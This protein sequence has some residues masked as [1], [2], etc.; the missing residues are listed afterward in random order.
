MPMGKHDGN[1]RLCIVAVLALSQCGCC[2]AEGDAEPARRLSLRQPKSPVSNF[3]SALEEV[4]DAEGR[5]LNVGQWMNY[6]YRGMSENAAWCASVGTRDNWEYATQNLITG[7]SD[8]C[9]WWCC[10]RPLFDMSSFTCHNYNAGEDDGWCFD[11]ETGRDGKIY[12][13][14]LH[15]NVNSGCTNAC[16]CCVDDTTTTA[17]TTTAAAG[18]PVGEPGDWQCFVTTDF[19]FCSTI[20][21]GAGDGFEYDLASRLGGTDACDG[22]WCCRRTLGGASSSSVAATQGVQG[23]GSTVT[24]TDIPGTTLPDA[25]FDPQGAWACVELFMLNGNDCSDWDGKHVDGW[26][27]V[28]ADTAGGSHGVSCGACACCRQYDGPAVPSP[29]WEGC[30]DHIAAGKDNQWCETIGDGE[31]DGKEYGLSQA[32]FPG[33]EMCWC[34]QRTAS[35]SPA[36]GAG[37]TSAPSPS[38]TVAG[39]QTTLVTTMSTAAAPAPVVN[40]N[41]GLPPVFMHVMPWFVYNKQAGTGGSHWVMNTPADDFKRKHEAAAHT[42]PALGPYDSGDVDYIDYQ[43]NLWRQMGLDGII[44]NW[45]GTLNLWDFPDN[46]ARADAI[47]DRVSGTG[48]KFA[49]CYEDWTTTA[50]NVEWNVQP[51]GLALDEA[52]AQFHKDFEYMRDNYF[53]K[54]GSLTLQGVDGNGGVR[55]VVFCFGP[56][57][58]LEKSI[59]DEMLDT[60]FGPERWK[61]PVIITLYS[62]PEVGDGVFSWFPPMEQDPSQF[63]KAQIK[64]KTTDYFN[65]FFT[66]NPV[67]GGKYVVGS[68]FPGFMDYYKEGGAGDGYGVLPDYNGETLQ[69]SI[70]INKAAMPWMIQACTWNDF[71]EGTVF[72]PAWLDPTEF[73]DS[74]YFRLRAL[75]EKIRGETLTDAE[76]EAVTGRYVTRT[77][78]ADLLECPATAHV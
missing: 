18:E 58:L 6:G 78:S 29:A 48:L 21:T 8:L 57:N 70:D 1:L 52:K 10:R 5:R 71:Q 44:I 68:V 31:N 67:G 73:Q 12:A 47:V 38:P 46:L 56:R 4:S 32:Q 25:N 24:S 64:Q 74:A 26:A 51:T 7:S 33:C 61:R 40:V 39:T 66:D 43:V 3:S 53:N 65:T 14:T 60:V 16:Q 11:G 17:I 37:P 42:K 35:A 20:G 77:Q 9:N 2:T 36:P 76:F 19:T 22:C 63:T 50:P 75:S 34:C 72:E 15:Q 23:P 59:W 55:P 45:Y 69:Q 27:Y 49:I 62:A 28:V 54:P 13:L 41:G 30:F